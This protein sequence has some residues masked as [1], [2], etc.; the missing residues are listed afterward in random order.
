M[1]RAIPINVHHPAENVTPTGTAAVPR[2][3]PASVPLPK[4]E[5]VTA[6][7]TAAPASRA[8]QANARPLQ[9]EN[10]T[11]TKTAAAVLAVPAIVAELI[12]EKAV[13]REQG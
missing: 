9:T 13:L 12:M 1:S 2:V 4:T 10:V 8:F 5:S 3:I 7:K 11:P 6:T